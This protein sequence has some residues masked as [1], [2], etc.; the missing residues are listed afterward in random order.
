MTKELQWQ[1]DLALVQRTLAGDK[2][3]IAEFASRMKCIPKFLSGMNRDM[4]RFLSMEDLEDA[5]Q[6]VAER[7]WR[8]RPKFTG[9]S[10]IETWV[11]PYARHVFRE[12]AATQSRDG[13]RRSGDDAIDAVPSEDPAVDEVMDLQSEAA[14]TRKAMDAMDPDLVT[15]IEE[16]LL[17][18]FSFSAIAANRSL[19]INTVK[20]RYYR[21]VSTLR[22]ALD[23]S[24]PP[25]EATH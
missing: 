4:N 19:N 11:Y 9:R 14:R 7:V 1:Q 23:R 21:G 5:G 25:S 13:Y 17:L 20:A 22:K 2:E 6:E 10:R 12:F 8:D 15:L 3:A 16:H 24:Q 18:E